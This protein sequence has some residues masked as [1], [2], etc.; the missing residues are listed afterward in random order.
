MIPAKKKKPAKVMINN[1]RDDQEIKDRIDTILGLARRDNPD[2]TYA[3]VAG[4]IMRKGLEV[5]ESE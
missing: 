5:V 4:H 1:W 3:E 2:L